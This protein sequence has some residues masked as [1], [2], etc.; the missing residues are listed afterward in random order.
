MNF[1]EHDDPIDDSTHL[2]A[3]DFT[4]DFVDLQSIMILVIIRH[5]VM[6]YHILLFV[7]F[8]FIFE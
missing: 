7:I 4:D 1:T 5:M 3:S 8:K 2:D 6:Y